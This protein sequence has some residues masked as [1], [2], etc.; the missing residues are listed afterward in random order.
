MAFF[1]SLCI[2]HNSGDQDVAPTRN[3]LD[4]SRSGRVVVKN[5][6]DLRDR[7]GENLVGNEGVRP[8]GLKDALAGVDFSGV[9]GQIDQEI[10][11]FGLDVP[12]LTAPLHLVQR[13]I[14]LPI[15]QAEIGLHP[16]LRWDCIVKAGLVQ[17]GL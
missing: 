14:D 12:D 5:L 15:R 8:D 4:V 7:V 10:H 1:L 16:L 17:E 2:L 13:R 6:A 3:R 11:H 9:T